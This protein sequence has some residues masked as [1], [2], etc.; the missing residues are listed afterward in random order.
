[1]SFVDLKAPLDPDFNPESSYEEVCDTILNALQVMGPE[2]TD[3]MKKA[4]TGAVGSIMPITSENQ[5]APF[6]RVHMVP[7]HISY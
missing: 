1:M 3:A 2:Y 4:M 6:V 5:L 7:I